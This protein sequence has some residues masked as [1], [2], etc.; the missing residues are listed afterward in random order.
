[1]RHY[2]VMFCGDVE[3]V[4][5]FI[6]DRKRDADSFANE[7]FEYYESC[8]DDAPHHDKVKYALKGFSSQSANAN[9]YYSI[10][11]VTFSNGFIEKVIHLGDAE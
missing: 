11:V 6:T 7:I 5:L 4:P 8:A 3:Q 9:S 1:M 2:V 10:A